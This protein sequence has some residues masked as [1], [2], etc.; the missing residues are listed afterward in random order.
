[1]LADDRTKDVLRTL[2][3]GSREEALFILL[4]IEGA[5]A[6]EFRKL[7]AREEH[8]TYRDAIAILSPDAEGTYFQYRFSDP[9]YVMS[10]AVLQAI[11]Q[12]GWPVAGRVLDLCGGCGH[13]TRVLARL[14]RTHAAGTA[15]PVLADVYFWKLWLAARFTTPE[16][17][18]V[19]C[20]ANQPLPFRRDT[21]SMVFLLDAFPYVWQR[22]LLAE[23]M[24]RLAG[25]GG[26]VVM[27]HLHSA[28]GT[29]FAAGMALTPGA[30]EDLFASHQPRL[31]SDETLLND[32]IE[33][34][35]LD[36][37]CNV[38][39][40]ELGDEPSLTLIA[41]QRNDL[42]RK[43]QLG[44]ELSVE[45]ELRVNPLYT[46][47][48]RQGTTILT[49]KFPSPEYEEEF[50]ACRRYLPAALAIE[51]DLPEKVMIETARLATGLD[52]GELRRR[53]ILVDLPPRYY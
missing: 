44:D 19:C 21:F 10:Q 22:R 46:A 38:S 31:F 23:E 9:T 35:T 33:R 39:P 25:Q 32:V 1:M 28:R 18:P 4:G 3:A 2:E 48:R 8:A 53:R 20:D 30:D 24:M 47:E 12:R 7:L 41:S 40:S 43:Y 11:A 50:G 14:T 16:C 37:T 34:Q 52:Y 5:A 51:G 17:A 15:P 27:P 26:V 6:P 29:N 13:L 36:L 45:G 49:L 42:F